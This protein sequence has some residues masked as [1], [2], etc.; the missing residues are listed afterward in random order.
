MKAQDVNNLKNVIDSLIEDACHEMTNRQRN[1]FYK[2]FTYSQPTT[3]YMKGANKGKQKAVY[4]IDEL[5][6]QKIWLMLQPYIYTS[7]T[8]SFYG[9]YSPDVEDVIA[10]IYYQ[11]I[12]N[13]RYYGPVYNG[14]KFSQRLG[15]IVNNVLTNN[16]KSRDEKYRVSDM[17]DFSNYLGKLVVNKIR[18]NETI[19]PQV[20]RLLKQAESDIEEL[21]KHNVSIS[22]DYNKLRFVV[23]YYEAPKFVDVNADMDAEETQ[24]RKAKVKAINSSS[25]L[26]VNNVFEDT[27]F[28][29]SIPESYRDVAQ[30]ILSGESVAEA[31]RN[32]GNYDCKNYREA[33]EV[34]KSAASSL[35]YTI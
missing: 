10:D 5:K 32:E 6:F 9:K 4:H 23:V 11:I 7:A 3:H 18:N 8:N 33:R 20:E 29:L 14:Q 16:S 2:D 1:T 25:E 21:Y 24:T 28:W 31:L 34:L 35:K 12:Y 22:R 15:L 19:T 17:H 27:E 26:T 30:R 13:L